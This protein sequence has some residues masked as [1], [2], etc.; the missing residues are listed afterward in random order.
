[1]SEWQPI[2]SAPK[3]GTRIDLWWIWWRADTD[4]FLG[5]RLP[6]CYWTSAAGVHERWACEWSSIPSNSRPTYWMPR[7]D[8][9][10]TGVTF[11]V[12]Q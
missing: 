8:G 10:V 5:R 9:P 11:P 6:D 1:M 3:D 2:D 12:S 4:E 7:P